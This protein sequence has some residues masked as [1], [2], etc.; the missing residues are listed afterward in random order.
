LEIG[1]T[2]D[3]TR[4]Q[5]IFANIVSPLELVGILSGN[6]RLGIVSYEYLDSQERYR[7]LARDGVLVIAHPGRKEAVDDFLRQTTRGSHTMTFTYQLLREK[8]TRDQ[9]VLYTVGIPLVLLVTIAI[10]LVVGAI[11][12][13]AFMRRLP[14]FG[15]LHAVGHSKG[16]LARRLTLETAGLALAGWV[17]GVLLACGVMAILS[18]AV[19]AP[20]GLA[21]NPL[22]VTELM[23]VAPMPLAVIG[24]TLFTAVRALGHMDAVAIVERGEL[25]LEG[26]RPGRAGGGRAGSL[27]Q[28]LAPT[29]FY[30]RHM[31]QAAVLIGAMTLMIVSTALFVFVAQVFDDARQPMLTH[32]SQMSLVSPSALPLE[33]PVTEQ[34][35]AHPAV[36][37]AI[38]AYVFSPLGISIPPVTPNYP[39]E[40]YGV[41]AEDMAYL[42]ELLRLKLAEGNLPRPGTNGI[43]IPWTFARNRNIQVGD[44][45]GNRA[46][47]IFPDAPTLPS[48]LVVSGIFAP[49]KAYAEEIWLSFISLEFVEKNRGT[50]KADLSLI[51]VPRAG[52]KA[53][54]DTWLENHIA[55]ESHLVFTYGNQTALF[56]EQARTL[57]FIL[58]LMESIIALVA[59][60]TL[61]GLNYIF[62]AQR[63]A[64]FGV[65]NALGFAR[66]QLVWR[67]VR[68]TVFTTGAAW[69]AAMLGCA[70]ILLYLQ[71]GVYDPAGLQ[72]NFFNP[73][74]WLFTLPVPAAVFAV[75]AGAVGW[76]L[77]RLDP[78]AVIERR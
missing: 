14:E 49:A 21:Y 69:L 60:L 27:S 4:D 12:Q 43:V 44:V 29:T 46:H 72:L 38:P 57:L 34:V 42:V 52:Q 73:T 71:H 33:A 2:L 55:G 6:V 58:S 8:V 45:I 10:A 74:P 37:R 75:S 22:Q 40:A 78:V 59:A 53:S 23:F 26:E 15:T 32:L 17:L 9:A 3:R 19:Y 47:P 51:V 62:V 65:L 39:G 1:D 20:K 31:R 28:P 41:T 5:T 68:E 50:W 66:I 70:A 11:N 7:D 64:E 77:A 24:S 61:V 18:A 35:R 36:E 13:L 25:S 30:R 56:Q 48:E 54:L 63:R 67:I 16:W 76:A